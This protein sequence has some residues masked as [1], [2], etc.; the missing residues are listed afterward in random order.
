MSNKNKLK[1]NNAL[2]LS[3]SKEDY[4]DNEQ[5]LDNAVGDDGSITISKKPEM[6]TES[7]VNETVKVDISGVMDALGIDY[8]NKSPEQKIQ[9]KSILNNTMSN[10][11]SRGLSNMVFREGDDDDN[12]LDWEDFEK[13]DREIEYGISNEG[14]DELMEDLKRSGKPIIK[15]NETINARIKKSDLINYFKNKNNVK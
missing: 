11:R 6:A 8:F 10:L 13:A 9:I 4:K 15:I 12:G 2:N 5:T 1:E 3:V 14:F 7:E